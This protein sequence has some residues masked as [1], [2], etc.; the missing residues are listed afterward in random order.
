MASALSQWPV[1]LHL[2]SPMAPYFRGQDVLLAADCV[3]YALGDFHG[4][5]LTGK[6]LLIACPKLDQ[7]QTSYLEKL[8]A[9]IDQAQIDTLTIARME[10]PCCGGLVALAREAAHRAERKVPI[11]EIMVGV[12][13]EILHEQWVEV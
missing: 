6:K 3:A 9:L 1:Q 4:R 8:I 11:K 10:V 7:G 12:Q 2:I 13:G 5:L